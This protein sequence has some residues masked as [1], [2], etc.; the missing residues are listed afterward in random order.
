MNYLDLLKTNRDN[1]IIDKQ[2]DS[3]EKS[4]GIVLP[5]VFKS[6]ILLYDLSKIG[7]E[8]LLSYYDSNYDA[9]LQLYEAKNIKDQNISIERWFNLDE[10]MEQME[11]IYTEDD[12][13]I[14][15]DFLA[16]GESFDQGIILLGIKEHNL[17][18]IFIES[19]LS[20][21]RIK[22]VNSNIFD[23]LYD[24]KITPIESYL[25]SGVKLKDLY[26]NWGEDF[27]RIRE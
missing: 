3:F 26:K 20:E 16:I 18:E 24:F 1:S 4:K 27:W 14:K 10:I 19:S 9:I 5:K 17:D 6:L 15:E 2:I 13:D 23:F 22:K 11:M 21:L 12:K 7:T 25:P 8:K